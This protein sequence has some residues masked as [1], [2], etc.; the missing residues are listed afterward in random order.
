MKKLLGSTLVL[1]I[2]LVTAPAF[3]A[4]YFQTLL[5]DPANPKMSV[6]VIYTS[7]LVFDGAMTDVALVYHKADK[8]NTLWPQKAL[9]LGLEPLSWT[10][11][12]LGFGGNRETAFFSAGVSVNVAPTLLGPIVK[13]LEAI[14]GK[15]ATFGSLILDKDGNGIK[16][17]LRW[18]ADILKRGGLTNINDLSFP[19]RY[20][21]GY[22]YQF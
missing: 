2:L 19:P 13:G 21:I 10:L 4:P 6:S 1:A 16:L 17:S 9:D 22:T 7:K 15:A 5:Q 11:L 12:E 14:G 8:A 20:G 3:A 18:K